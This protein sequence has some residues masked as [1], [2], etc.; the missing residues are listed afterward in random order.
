M[1][2]CDNHFLQFPKYDTDS[3]LDY[4][5]KQIASNAVEPGEF[6]QTFRSIIANL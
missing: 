3:G 2:A 6:Y 5:S 4:E 1:Y